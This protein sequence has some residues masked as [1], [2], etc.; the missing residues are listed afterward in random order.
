RISRSTTRL[1]L[2]RLE[3]RNAASDTL[4]YLMHGALGVGTMAY[5]NSLGGSWDGLVGSSSA[6]VTPDSL[7][8]TQHSALTEVPTLSAV[9]PD[10][11]SEGRKAS[12]ALQDW[13]REQSD[14]NQNKEPAADRDWPLG[15]T[16]GVASGGFSFPAG[17]LFAANQQGEG[18]N[19]EGRSHAGTSDSSS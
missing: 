5:L 6:L 17:A 4:G 8:T 14:L 18:A 19:S 2:V 9:S 3:D 1:D 11:W 12:S 7:F 13:L 10:F 16:G 15:A